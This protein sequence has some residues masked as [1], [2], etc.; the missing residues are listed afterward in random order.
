MVGEYV[1]DL[2]VENSVI[3]EIKAAKA[4]AP[5]HETQLIH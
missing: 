4:I 2:I 1:A 5:E 3:V